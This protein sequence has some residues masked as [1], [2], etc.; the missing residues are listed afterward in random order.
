MTT[1]WKLSETHLIPSLHHSSE[2]SKSSSHMGVQKGY[3]LGPLLFCLAINRHCEQLRYPLH[4][5]YLDD[6]SV[7]GPMDDVL[8]DL[9]VI[10]PAENL[11]LFFNYSKCEVICHNDAVRCHIIVA[12]PGARVV[13]PERV[14]LLES[15]LR[16]VV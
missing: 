14:C 13:D 7:G 1:Y 11:G 15:P 5:M 16:N 3:Q 6:V 8:H 4:V 9:D 2:G 12:L 10:K